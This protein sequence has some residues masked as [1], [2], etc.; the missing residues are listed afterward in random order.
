[1]TA[2]PREHAFNYHCF[3]QLIVNWHGKILIIECFQDGDIWS[4]E[5][6][7]GTCIF[8]LGNHQFLNIYGD[9]IDYNPNFAIKDLDRWLEQ[10][11]D[12]WESINDRYF[13]TDEEVH[14]V[15]EYYK[16]E[17]EKFKSENKNILIKE[18]K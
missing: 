11:Y 1:M 4:D 6:V 3:Q 13:G 18:L 10:S 7:Y 12:E 16:K 5:E 2:F 17:I 8:D 14:S 15:I 9:Y